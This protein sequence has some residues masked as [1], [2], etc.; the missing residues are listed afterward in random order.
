MERVRL[1]STAL[2]PRLAGRPA[3]GVVLR[4]PRGPSRVSPTTAG[5]SRSASSRGGRRSAAS[6]W[7]STSRSG[8]RGEPS[9]GSRSARCP[10]ARWRPRGRRDLGRRPEPGDVRGLRPD[11]GRA[12]A[13]HLLHVP[14]HC[15]AGRRGVRREPP[16]RSTAGR[17]GPRRRGWALVVAG[18]ARVVR[19][20]QARP[21]RPGARVH[22]GMLPGGVHRRRAGRATR[23]SRPSRP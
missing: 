3:C 1:D 22:R 20:G 16:D 19:R 12:G 7:R 9:A 11:H 18:G 10:G 8:S 17:A 13:A 15:R 4:D 6:S 14:G 23:R 5:W 21:A 2:A